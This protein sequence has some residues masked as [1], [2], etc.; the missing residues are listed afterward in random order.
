MITLLINSV[1]SSDLLTILGV[2]TATLEGLTSIFLVVMKIITIIK[3]K[4][5]STRD[6]LAA[7]DKIKDEDLK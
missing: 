5:L 3:S 4:D 7:L 6:K 2:I 1:V